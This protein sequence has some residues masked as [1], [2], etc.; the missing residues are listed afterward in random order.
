MTEKEKQHFV[1]RLK[2]N[3]QLNRTKSLKGTR[4]IDSNVTADF[5]CTIGTPQK[6]TKKRHRI[7]QFTDYEGKVMRVVTN[8]MDMTAEEIAGLYKSRWA[9][10]S[11]FR[12][13]KQ[14][15]NVPVLFGTTS[16]A[17]YNQL[18]AAM[19]AYVLLKFL[20]VHGS[21]K[22]QIKPLSFA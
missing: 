5:T 12:W 22:N 8:L 13:I 19:I 3:V 10:E 17:V 11:F 21:K 15:L 20:H 18:F 7:V 16:N 6:Q 1:I 9:I 4:T 14:N 2:D